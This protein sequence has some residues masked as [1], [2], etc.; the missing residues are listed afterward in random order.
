MEAS[1]DTKIQWAQIIIIEATRNKV[2]LNRRQHDRHDLT[3]I[4]KQQQQGHNKIPILSKII[5]K[6][7]LIF[8]IATKP[9]IISNDKIQIISERESIIIREETVIKIR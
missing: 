4:I 3:I 8:I 9:V 2:T 7:N 5:N 6:I 1:N